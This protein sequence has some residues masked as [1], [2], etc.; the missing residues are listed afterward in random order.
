MWTED[1]NDIVSAIKSQCDVQQHAYKKLSLHYNRLHL[2][3]GIA[4]VVIGGLSS[5]GALIVFE[6][7]D[8]PVRDCQA[9]CPDTD[10]SG[11]FDTSIQCDSQ[12]W[13]RL[14]LNIITCLSSGFVGI[15]MFLN[16]K[17]KHQSA[18]QSSHDYSSLSHN[19]DLLLNTPFE[20]RG[21]P[22][23]LIKQI[24]DTY[25]DINTRALSLPENYINQNQL[26]PPA[27]QSI[28]DLDDRVLEDL[29]TRPRHQTMDSDNHSSE[30]VKI[31]MSEPHMDS[32]IKFELS[33]LNH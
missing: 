26:T 18:K 5:I 13:V 9:Y 1:L 20:Q 8:H 4:G 2:R 14:S 7:C 27:P 3:M 30:D 33:R 25:E 17:E 22:H 23:E 28:K 21:D 11:F 16:Y 15:Q 12:K 24:Q 6:D 31:H 32:A 29:Q 19:L 10:L